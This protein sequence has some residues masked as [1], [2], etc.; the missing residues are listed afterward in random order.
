M[1]DRHAAVFLDR[2]GVLIEDRDLLVAPAEIHVLADAPAALTRLHEAG[3][4]LVVVSNQAV[5]ARGL[6]TERDLDAIHARM[7]ELL[8][9]AGSPELDAIYYCPHHPD[10]NLPAYRLTCDCRKPRPG[11]LLRAAREH[12]LDLRAS[13]LVGDRLTDV[14][15]GVRAGCRTVLVK[16]RQ[17]EAPPI[18]TADPLDDLP[19]PDFVCESLA[20]AADWIVRAP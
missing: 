9:Q 10:A 5:V 16:T 6:I 17:S 15:A 19:Q 2:D 11:M 1:T 8:R 20:A 14:A 18:V 3:F 7:R 12:N 4:R 13:F